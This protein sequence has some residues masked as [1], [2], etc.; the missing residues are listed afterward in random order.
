MIVFVVLI[1]SHVAFSDRPISFS[2][3][4]ELSI[5]IDILFHSLIIRTPLSSI[6]FSCLRAIS[7]GE[8]IILAEFET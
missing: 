4:E 5:G 6:Q 3:F 2:G 8:M 1:N 7:F